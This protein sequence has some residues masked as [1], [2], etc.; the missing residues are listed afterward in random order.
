M[1]ITERPVDSALKTALVNN[2]P[3]QYA[4]LVK[5][6]RPSRPDSLSGLV[7]TKYN[8]YTYLTDAS[9]NVSFDDGS[10][11]LLGVSNGTQTYLANKILSV[12]T[13]QE[14]TKASTSS[15]SL[16]IDGTGLGASITGKA[17]IATGGT[18][19]WDLTL[20]APITL[21]DILAQGFREG[22]KVNLNGVPFN[23]NS[24]R[25]NNVLRVSKI[26]SDLSIGSNID[27][28]LKL[29]SEEI[30]S[31][32]LNKNA[33]DY[34]SFINREV[35]I[36]RAYFIDGVVIGTPEL[37]FKGIIYSV[38][39]EDSESGIRVTWGL[40]SHWG[41]FAQ[42]RGRVTSD[43]AHRALNEN[44][45][46]QPT[47]TLKPIYAYDKGFNHAEI[48]INTL[49]TYTVQVEKMDVKSKKGF[50]GIGAGVKTKKYFVTEERHTNLDFEFNAKNIPIVYGVRLVEG[51]GIFADTLN[52]DSST[53]YVAT[54]LSEG[55]IGAIYDVIIDGNSLICNDKAD[56]DARSTQTP[57]QTVQLV[58]RGR[59]D[60]G[61]ALGGQIITTT[62]YPFYDL[63][64]ELSSL[65]DFSNPIANWNAVGYNFNLYNFS[66]PQYSTSGITD[67]QTINL[68]SPQQISLDFY[69]GKAG[70]KSS[71]QLS[72]IAY[73]KDFKIQNSYWTGT[74]T[75]EYWGP[76]HRLLDTAYIVG[77]YKIAEGETTIPE[78]KYII[79]GKVIDCYNY[80]YSYT[81]DKSVS[82]E[83]ADSFTLGEMVT[84]YRS[85]TNAIINSN[86]QIIDKWNIINPDGSTNT[87]FRFD[88]RPSLSYD[89][90]DLPTI[91]KFY[92][93][94][95][96]NNIWTMITHNHNYL[97]G[98]VPYTLSAA[99]T[100]VSNNSGSI[101]FSFSG[102]T[103][104]SIEN[105]PIDNSP[106]LQLMSPAY[107]AVSG[108]LF[109]TALMVGSISGNTFTSGYPYSTFGAEASNVYAG[110][111]LVSKNTIKL[112]STASSVDGTYTGA[113][114]EVTR[115]NSVTGKSLVQYGE[116]LG[117]NGTN[118]IATIDTIWDF[119]PTNG[120]TVRVYPK[121]ADAR[122][123][124][125]P[126]I[127]LL[128]YI[129]SKTYGRGLNYSS[130]LN[131]PS[132]LES[133]RKCDTRSNVTILCSGTPNI[134]DIYKYVDGSVLVWQGEVVNVFSGDAGTYVEF[135]NCIGKITNKWKDWKSWNV[136]DVIYNSSYSFYRVVTRG[137]ITTEPAGSLTTGNAISLNNM[138]LV[139]V[140]GTGSAT[141]PVVL[142][143]GNPV[144]SLKNGTKISGYSL[145]DC[146]DI[147]FWR[148][149]GWDEH[150][151]RYVTKNQTNLIVDTGSP[152]FDNIN[153]FLEHF[154][155]ILRY[156]KGKYYL[157]VEEAEGTILTTDIRTI[158]TD[159]I[160]GKI[161]LTDE[162]ARSAFN[163][164]TAA[165]A[166]PANK[167]E[168]KS[169]S[170][171]NSEYLKADR[172][173]PKKGNLSIP[174]ITN[175]YNTRLLADSY[176]NKSRFGLSIN[177]TVRTHG[178][179][180]LAGTVIQ[181]VYPRY[182]WTVP[183]KKFRIESITYQPD[184]MADI[185]AKEY[186]DSFYSLSNL[187]A[188]TGSGPTL[189]G[190]KTGIGSPTNLIVTSADTLDELM[191]GVELFWDNDPAAN[192][193][194]VST[195]VYGGQSPHLFVTVTGISTVG[196]TS[197]MTT[198][199]DHGLIPGMP[200]YPQTTL[201]G[202]SDSD[203]YYVVEAP[204][205]TTFTMSSTK[206]A[207]VG[208][209][210]TEGSSLNIKI[211][212][213]TLLAT[214]PV[215]IRSYIDSIV[216]EGT[217]RV[218]K[219]YWVRHKVDQI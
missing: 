67:G 90:D 181:V 97:T 32:L 185:V 177:F 136:G 8:R 131:L 77:K 18:N 46:P 202:I 118:K 82:G 7:S 78:I 22:D 175:Y 59:A 132:W 137:L 93:K 147:N 43:S 85:D 124:I 27:V 154:N 198:N 141:L 91:T 2:Q 71:A 204:T 26:D 184:G 182:D 94:D 23:I 96:S 163:S 47:S 114:I 187:R 178:I 129:T 130:D 121:Y 123:S 70:Q 10:K 103:G 39:F 98:T 197:T 216:N 13:I 138:S 160:I 193:T 60:K 57:D 56:F 179:L 122:V 92:M 66:L 106:K 14:T 49:A 17:N 58:C 117:Y 155:G 143:N 156:T 3:I 166:D 48:A 15:T 76:N 81:H 170:F 88:V 153:S 99:V 194:Y 127:Q 200:I 206:N 65:Y 41:D 45:V 133:A 42:V 120:D 4:H 183:G 203:I 68:T 215:P 113:M 29:A 112:P 145:Y 128:D 171:F 16:V 100:G 69:S 11:D 169:I 102:D 62:P 212:T 196:S 107:D 21:D 211:R 192:S 119:I 151:Q 140:S 34:S 209:M 53:V 168:A 173:V 40:T 172:N 109:K 110:N 6:E 95:S 214:V 83:S 9:I 104:I 105:D 176:L 199:A 101:A 84:L 86:V 54:V 33:S 180:L 75:A 189:I 55:E 152:L 167:F 80:D 218:E 108:N 201:N 50:L 64:G 61:D 165:F 116:I 162:G 1:N 87:R 195:E 30:I 73:N 188:G 5:F 213:A 158:T 79:K 210:F 72:Q 148:L 144:Q 52:T 208:D 115:Y 142:S 19:L 126:A 149:S 125:N 20:L 36:Y 146:D 12:G 150:A 139:K 44:G 89:I 135:T 74:D 31:I 205:T 219:Y 38:N 174:G 207:V 24:F 191:N 25:S 157:D 217:G 63:S 111:Y 159:D 186:D 51:I 28:T 37:M 35:Y 190:T 164:L 134:G 161:Q